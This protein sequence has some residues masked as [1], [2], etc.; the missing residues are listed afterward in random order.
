MSV[1]QVPFRGVFAPKKP[2]KSTQLQCSACGLDL[3]HRLIS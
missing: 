1:G 3:T 2:L